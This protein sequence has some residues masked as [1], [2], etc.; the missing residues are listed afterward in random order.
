MA[1]TYFYTD[2]NGTFDVSP[3]EAASFLKRGQRVNPDARV[4]EYSE[5]G[6]IP[7]EYRGLGVR[8]VYPA[9]AQYPTTV[10]LCTATDT[11]GLAADP[12]NDKQVATRRAQ[13]CPDARH[14]TWLEAETIHPE[15]E[16]HVPV[17][18]VLVPGGYKALVNRLI[19]RLP[20]RRYDMTLI[21]TEDTDPETD[22]RD[23]DAEFAEAVQRFPELFAAR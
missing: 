13:L 6:G 9:P 20:V 8:Q 19:K 17:A 2:K 3:E 11:W 14:W 21:Q 23:Y 16:Q 7:Q 22:D 4:C 10:H 1:F 5:Y 12:V 18:F 15:L